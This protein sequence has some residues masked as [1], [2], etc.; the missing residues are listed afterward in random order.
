L[1]ENAP[2]DQY[3]NPLPWYTYPAVHYLYS[4][5]FSKSKVLEWG[6]GS[7]TVFWGKRA[8][9]VFT[10][11]HDP[12]W[13]Q[14]IV[15]KA[16]SLPVHVALLEEPKT[17][18]SLPSFANDQVFDVVIVDGVYRADCAKVAVE[19]LASN[20]LIVF[21][22]S[23]WFPKTCGW[24]RSQGLIQVDLN[25][26]TPTT[27]TTS[28]TTLF[29]R[30]NFVPIPKFNQFSDSSSARLVRDYD[31]HPLYGRIGTQE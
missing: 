28:V 30:P 18:I 14:Q 3:G 22:N 6:G 25:G 29:L 26:L 15:E 24:L 19:R 11:E 2:L 21:D 1:T 4:L 27:W 7:S 5:D 17:Y 10:V 20:G 31:R 16:N 12:V 13:F 9:T 23:D 8:K